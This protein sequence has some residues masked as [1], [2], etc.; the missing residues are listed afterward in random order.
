M[1]EVEIIKV[2]SD[3]QIETLD[4]L[5]KEIWNEHFVKIIGQEQVDYML[6]K[7]QC[8]DAMKQ[9]ISDGYEYFELTLDG[10]SIGYMGI[11]QEDTETMFL[12]KLYVKAECRGKHI[13]TLAFDY[14]KE[15]SRELGLKKIYLTCNKYNKNT[16]AVY[17][18]FGFVKTDEQD[19]PIGE[20]FVMEDYILT[21]Y[22]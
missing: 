1:G 11:H 4:A 14:L 13:A 15:L 19:N 12:S 8:F 10:Q 9:Q 20:G 17:D 3:D 22:L 5:A 21:Y 6:K 18:H 2:E 7:F 16:L